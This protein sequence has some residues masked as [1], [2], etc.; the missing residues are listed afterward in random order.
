MRRSRS[1]RRMQAVA[2]ASWCYDSDRPR[3]RGATTR[4]W[5]SGPPGLH[6]PH[7]RPQ[8]IS[9]VESPSVSERTYLMGARMLCTY[10]Y[11]FD[12]NPLEGR[13]LAGMSRRIPTRVL[14]SLF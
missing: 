3:R 8:P 12:L 6:C 11:D 13:L 9:V 1:R 10:A 5:D 14:Y 7:D 4:G 2:T